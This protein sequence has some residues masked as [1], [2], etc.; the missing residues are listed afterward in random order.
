MGG[1]EAAIADRAPPEASGEVRQ[2]SVDRQARWAAVVFAVYIGVAFVALLYITRRM[3][4]YA[5]DWAWLTR[6]LDGNGLFKPYYQ[7]WITLPLLV[8]HV[9]YWAFG[10]NYLPYKLCTIGLHLALAVL[11]RVIM[12]RAGVNP[13]LATVAAGTFVLFG[14]GH[15]GIMVSVQ[16]SL[17]GSVVFGTCHLLSADHDGPFS[18]LDA[19]GI[20]FGAL[21]LISSGVGTIMVVIVGIS[22]FIR[23]GWRM[24]LLHVVPLALLNVVWYAAERRYMSHRHTPHPFQEA[25]RWN[26]TGQR[27]VFSALGG[28]YGVVAI[29]LGGMLVVGLVLAWR[30]LSL[31]EFRRQ[32]AVPAAM[33]IG[34]PV[35]FSLISVQRGYLARYETTSRFVGLAA[36]LALPALAIAADALVREWR[37]ATPIV[38]ALLVV[39]IPANI[40]K[41]PA[42]GNFPKGFFEHDKAMLLGAAYSPLG[43][44][45]PGTLQPYN[46]LFHAPDVT[47]DFLLAARR[48]GRLPSPPRLTA[49]ERDELQVRLGVE[50][51]A[52]DIPTTVK[53]APYYAPL[54]LRPAQGA[55]YVVD[56]YVSINYGEHVATGLTGPV[57]FDPA[58]GRILHILVPGLQLTV[59]NAYGPTRP[60]SFCTG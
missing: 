19:L 58:S 18:R 16:M 33:L 32:A 15:E 4:F 40:G 46:Q 14:P 41:F 51:V 48:A 23:R 31:P 1:K 30:P 8:Y 56:S 52:A 50:Q 47:M 20:A 12:R 34:G 22:V 25:I 3:W 11:L 2:S 42:E 60:F 13:W 39:G 55:V 43:P 45:V 49:A 21:G 38:V 28:G 26:I 24:A 57:Y 54:V 17:V 27:A 6:R 9:L 36:A 7:H 29:L 37:N 44:K 53:C 10:A 59:A 5:D 35:F